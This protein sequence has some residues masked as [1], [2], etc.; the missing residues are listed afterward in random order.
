MIKNERRLMIGTVV[1]LIAA[2]G[3]HAA[4]ELERQFRELPMKARRLTGPLFWMHGDANETKE[5][6]EAYIEKV[7]EGGNGNE[8]TAVIVFQG[9][10]ACVPGSWILRR[11]PR[12]QAPR[13]SSPAFGKLEEELLSVRVF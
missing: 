13:I 8:G 7:A 10:C 11:E 9:G 1:L 2:A 6:L 4:D 5:R 3:L 12:L